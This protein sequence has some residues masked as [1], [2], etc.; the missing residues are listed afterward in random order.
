MTLNTLIPYNWHVCPGSYNRE[1]MM[2][3]QGKDCEASHE[4]FERMLCCRIEGRE[5]GVSCFQKERHPVTG[6]AMLC[7]GIG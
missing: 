3:E 4:V 5:Q 7:A 1:E 6:Y 2:N